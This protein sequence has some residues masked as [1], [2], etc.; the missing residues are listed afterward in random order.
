[1]P[2][3][4]SATM[5]SRSKQRADALAQIAKAGHVIPGICQFCG[6]TEKNACVFLLG[7]ACAWVNDRRTVCNSTICLEK[8]VHML[9]RVRAEFFD[10]WEH[11]EMVVWGWTIDQ[12]KAA[13]REFSGRHKP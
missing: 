4:R 8:Y 11:G 7:I 3:K 12:V 6:C 13:L 10:L 2:S 1:M 9:E 5:T